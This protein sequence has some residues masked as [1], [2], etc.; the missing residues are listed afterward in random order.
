MDFRQEKLTKCEVKEFDG[1]GNLKKR[2]VMDFTTKPT[3]VT[4]YDVEGNITDM[5]RQVAT[6]TGN[7]RLD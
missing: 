1:N 3:I 6:K 4:V 7:V 2:V 5:Y